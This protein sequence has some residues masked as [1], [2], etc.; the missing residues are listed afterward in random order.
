MAPPAQHAQD[1]R[2]P[3]YVVV[4]PTL[5]RATLQSCLDALAAAAGPPPRQVVLVDDRRQTPCPLPV[6]VPGALAGLTTVVTLE[7]RGPAAA[8]N[9]GW[10]AAPA[11][12]WVVFLDDDV[13]VGPRWRDDLAADL[14]EPDERVAGVQGIIEVPLP[15]GRAPTDWERGTAGLAGA[16]WITA[17]MAYRRRA[18]I[19]AGGFDERFPRAFRE[20]ADLALRLLDLGWTLRRG[21]R[22]TVHPVRPAGRW[23]SLRAQ[24]GNRDD[25]LMR[26]L[27]GRRWQHRAGAATGRRP[28]HWATCV[29]AA[30]AGACLGA[31]VAAPA[32]T[33][34]RLRR[35]GLAAGT[36]WLI[37]TADFAAARIR[38]GPRDRDEVVTMAL[39]SVAIPPLAVWHWMAGWWAHRRTGP[40]PPPPA[41]VLFDRDGTLIRDVPYNGDPERVAPM[42]GAAEAVARLRRAGIR[43]GVITNQ[44]AVG[45]GLITESQLRAVN[46]RVEALLGPFG[47]WAVCPHHPDAGCACRKPAPGLITQAAADLG[48]DTAQCLVIGDIGTDAAAAWAAGARAI[49][50]PTARTLPAETAGVPAATELAAAVAAVLGERRLRCWSPDHNSL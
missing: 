41:A 11:A 40:W 4:I 1:G 9:A 23:A 18:L 13:R 10:R 32:A 38:P 25:A 42:P 36:G 48:A 21:A 12:D 33:R 24:A 14:R 17:D 19:A 35:A 43:L 15:G 50:V 26:R 7:G 5:G 45:L 46:R 34:P 28:F 37:A 31:S 29:L 44:S 30:G 39:T 27:H 3:D 8:R 49:L 22:T 6:R 2:P 47:T 16:R 20:D